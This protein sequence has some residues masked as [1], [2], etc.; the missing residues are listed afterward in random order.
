[1]AAYSSTSFGIIFVSVFKIFNLRPE[2]RRLLLAADAELP[3]A[4]A[5]S[6]PRPLAAQV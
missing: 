6:A 5:T 1:M 4:T 3:H 2:R